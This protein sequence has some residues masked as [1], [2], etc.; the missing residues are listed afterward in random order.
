MPFPHLAGL[1]ERRK[2][3]ASSFPAPHA[4]HRASSRSG[5]GPQ[6]GRPTRA[7][8]LEGGG[9]VVPSPPPRLPVAQG[10]FLRSY[11]TRMAKG[12]KPKGAL[13]S[14]AWKAR[15]RPISGYP[16]VGSSG[17][18][19]PP[20]GVW[21]GHCQGSRMGSGHFWQ[22]ESRGSE[23]CEFPRAGRQARRLKENDDRNNLGSLK[24]LAR[25]NGEV[26]PSRMNVQF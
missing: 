17:F 8:R 3:L 10:T 20:K 24:P 25:N 14:R 18:Q 19:S 7:L 9:N 23:V 6:R 16:L 1:R 21:L 11:P 2:P 12:A 22:A 13:I 4:S 15:F 5:S 26:A